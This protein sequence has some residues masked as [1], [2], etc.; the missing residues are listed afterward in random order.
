MTNIENKINN[1]S[2]DGRRLYRI[3]QKSFQLTIDNGS[4]LPYIVT[5]KQYGK[6]RLLYN[7][8]YKGLSPKT[9]ELK[10]ICDGF[11]FIE[12]KDKLFSYLDYEVID[13]NE[14]SVWK[15][16]KK[17]I[18]ID[19]IKSINIKY[20][21]EFVKYSEVMAKDVAEDLT[22]DEYSQLIFDR[23]FDRENELRKIMIGEM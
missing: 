7:E 3:Y 9:T 16:I 18:P 8:G 11:Y 23:V 13:G 10:H 1:T 15:L 4:P 2:I 19:M 14:I 5:F 20:D 21:V 17:G 12:K 6:W 22:F